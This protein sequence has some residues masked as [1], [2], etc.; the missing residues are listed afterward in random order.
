MPNRAGVPQLVC[1][2]KCEELPEVFRSE[3]AKPAA[4]G[5][6][7]K[8]VAHGH[9]GLLIFAKQF[10]LNRLV[11]AIFFFA[12]PQTQIFIEIGE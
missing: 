8:N 12:N 11:N 9:A 3:I 4:R 5:D 2:S 10:R 1:Q 6:L 7:V